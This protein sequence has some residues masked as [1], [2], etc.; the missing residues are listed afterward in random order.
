MQQPLTIELKSSRDMHSAFFG[1][2]YA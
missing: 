1:L 2:L